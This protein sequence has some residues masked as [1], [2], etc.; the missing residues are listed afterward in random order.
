MGKKI[1]RSFQTEFQI[2]HKEEFAKIKPVSR[3]CL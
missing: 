3:G 2:P 1:N